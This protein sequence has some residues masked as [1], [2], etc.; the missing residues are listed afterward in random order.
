M[1][2]VQ[3]VVSG[4]RAIVRRKEIL[5]SQ[6]AWL[7]PSTAGEAAGFTRWVGIEFVDPAWQIIFP[8]GGPMQ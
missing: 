3:P 6:S 5:A 8:I 2:E 4:S 1:M 7:G